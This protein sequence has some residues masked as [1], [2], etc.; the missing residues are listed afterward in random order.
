MKIVRAQLTSVSSKTATIF[1]SIGV[2]EQTVTL[3]AVPADMAAGD[4]FS[5]S[6]PDMTILPE[7]PVGMLTQL[8]ASGAIPALA[9]GVELNHA[10]VAIAATIDDAKKHPGLFVI[11]NTS[12]SGTAAHTVTLTTGTWDGTHQVATL[13]AAGKALAVWFDSAGNGVI[14]VNISTVAFS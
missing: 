3:T 9:K 5:M 13:A 12:A 8:T 6:W 4:Y 1:E 11:K 14:L 10:T 2:P 7:P